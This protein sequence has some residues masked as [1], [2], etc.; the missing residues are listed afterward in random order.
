M[1]AHIFNAL[2]WRA[3][4]GV[5]LVLESIPNPPLQRRLAL[6][7][8]VAQQLPR[9]AEFDLQA[10]LARVQAFADSMRVGD[11]A[12]RFS[13]QATQATLYSSA[14]A[15]LIAAQ[16][17]RLATLGESERAGW[18]AYFDSFQSP[19]DGLFRDPA[20]A[21]ETFETADWWGARHL[22]IHLLPAYVALGGRPRHRLA[23]LDAYKDEALLNRWFEQTAWDQPFTYKDDIDNKLMNLASALQ[24]ARDFQGD[25]AAGEAVS[26]IQ[27]MLLARI[28]P[29]TGMWGRAAPGDAVQLS[30]MVQFAYHL[31]PI[32]LYDGIAIGPVQPAVDSALQTQNALG[33][34]G[35]DICSSACE[36]IDSIEVL[37]RL[38]GPAQGEVRQA[39]YRAL[40]WVLVNQNADGGSVFR[41]RNALV[42]G[43]AQMAAAADQS[44]MFSSWFRML[45]VM[46]LQ[47][48]L[49]GVDRTTPRRVPGFYL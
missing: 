47:H 26:R 20:V 43:H 25:A 36:D 35:V 7:E 46:Q 19:E 49:T 37:V 3:L 22:A 1:I 38:A 27:R 45:S 23:Y 9:V 4:R 6:L 28:D 34:F 21:G 44:E 48:G 18:L 40:A 8:A 24:F 14:Y 30:R 12:Y 31:Y 17:G 13:A 39:L 2:R 33:G 10:Y 5:G 42:Y 41:R 16:S 15:C 32:F 29:R 11:H